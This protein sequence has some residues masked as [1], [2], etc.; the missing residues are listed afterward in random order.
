MKLGHFFVDFYDFGR[1]LNTPGSEQL[2]KS[3]FFIPEDYQWNY[4][5]FLDEKS[6]FYFKTEDTAKKKIVF[7]Y[8][9]F[10]DADDFFAYPEVDFKKKICTS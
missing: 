8:A 5:T 4:V 2:N 7:I 3:C 9:S 10:K 1:F 6:T